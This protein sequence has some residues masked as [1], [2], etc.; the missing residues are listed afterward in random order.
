MHFEVRNQVCSEKK[1]LINSS[2]SN[3][4]IYI[5]WCI[6][7]N[8]GFAY[9]E[10]GVIPGNNAIRDQIM[11]LKF[12]QKNIEKFGGDPNSV[13]IAGASSGGASVGLLI[14]SPKAEGQSNY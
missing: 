2:G 4:V 6:H 14:M 10:D 7:Y 13:T 1:N 11:A 9:T 8:A 12:V 5:L 3:F